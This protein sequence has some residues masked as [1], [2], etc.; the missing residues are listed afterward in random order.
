MDAETAIYMYNIILFTLKNME[1][2]A[3]AT[4]WMNLR[5]LCKAK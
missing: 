5:T 3:F 1:T 4:T 2:L